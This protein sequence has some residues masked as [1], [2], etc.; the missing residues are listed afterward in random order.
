[1]AREGAVERASRRNASL[2]ARWLLLIAPLLLAPDP[3]HAPTYREHP[4]LQLQRA[5]RANLDALDR[6]LEAAMRE[7]RQEVV[8]AGEVLERTGRELRT[9][10]LGAVG[11]PKE[12][13]ADF[14]RFV[15]RQLERSREVAAAGRSGD[16]RRAIDA[17]AALQRDACVGCHDAFRRGTSLR[18]PSVL[19][20]RSF[21]GAFESMH[22]GLALDDFGRIAREARQIETLAQVLATS[23]V[24]GALFPSDRGAR[25]PRFRDL[26]QRLS[27]AA[28]RVEG[29]AVRRDPVAV[30]DELR[31]M[32]RSSCLECHRAFRDR[33]S[34]RR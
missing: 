5:M 22:R 33:T 19:V 30:V 17:W 6:V 32:A 7:Q 26:L 29:A 13:D 28:V 20:M 10:D 1:M 2:R 24:A 23:D 27:T 4:E 14:D 25:D 12:R 15:D 31:E 9:L 21:L 8:R 18:E 34:A 3:G 11:L 16:F